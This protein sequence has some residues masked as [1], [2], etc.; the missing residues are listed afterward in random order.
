MTPICA[1]CQAAPEHTLTDAHG[2]VWR[3]E[4]HRMFGPL[5]LRADGEPAARQPG[6]RSAFWPAWKAWRTQQSK[7]CRQ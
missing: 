1:C 7:P 6:S 4:Q 3:F 5:I 2:R